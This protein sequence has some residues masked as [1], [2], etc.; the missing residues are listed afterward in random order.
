MVNEIKYLS[1]RK[2]DV[3]KS[4]RLIIKAIIA[5]TYLGYVG[6]NI[7]QREELK[8]KLGNYQAR[9]IESEGNLNYLQRMSTF[10]TKNP[11]DG[12]PSPYGG[13]FFLGFPYSQ[14]N[15][16]PMCGGSQGSVPIENL[17]SLEEERIRKNDREIKELEQKIANSRVF[18]LF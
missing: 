12:I 17:I 1:E 7:V 10:L 18:S 2:E 6:N 11:I 5:L 16:V 8:E 15:K 9:A 14:D 3:R 4:N 13:T